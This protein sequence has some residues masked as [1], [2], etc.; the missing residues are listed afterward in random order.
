VG[1]PRLQE[2]NVLR[3]GRRAPAFRIFETW[4]SEKLRS[5]LSLH[6]PARCPFRCYERRNER[7]V[8]KDPRLREGGKGVQAFSAR[9]LGKRGA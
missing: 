9:N 6:K 7:V 4:I 3:L 8:D 1:S 2:E 5:D